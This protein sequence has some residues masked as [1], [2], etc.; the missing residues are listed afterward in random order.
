MVTS[1]GGGDCG[2][3][4]AHDRVV[5]E[6]IVGAETACASAAGVVADGQELQMSDAGVDDALAKTPEREIE[7]PR[8]DGHE[9]DSQRDGGGGNDGTPGVTE[10]VADGESDEDDGHG[11]RLLS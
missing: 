9:H 6:P 11:S 4:S 8:G 3:C 10:H 5:A 2:T 1:S 7:K